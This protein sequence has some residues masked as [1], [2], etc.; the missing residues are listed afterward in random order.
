MPATYKARAQQM[1]D[2]IDQMELAMMGWP[3]LLRLP[4]R[5]GEPK[6]RDDIWVRVSAQAG[7]IYRV[8]EAVKEMNRI[9]NSEEYVVPPP[10]WER[11]KSRRKIKD[12]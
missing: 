4:E 1:R 10:D 5:W 9:I 3:Q 6:L 7:T 8:C 11:R 12:E 2:A